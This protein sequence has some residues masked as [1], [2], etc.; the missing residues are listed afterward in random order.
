MIAPEIGCPHCGNVLPGLSERL[1]SLEGENRR[2][3]RELGEAESELEHL[4]HAPFVGSSKHKTFHKPSCS[5]ASY[6]I[7]SKNLV[8]F[9]SHK[10]AEAAGYVPCKTCCA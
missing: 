8:E 2:L 4:G 1:L 7:G 9:S 6:I 5:W 10:D 3:R